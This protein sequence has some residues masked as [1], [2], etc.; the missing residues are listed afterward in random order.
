[1][2]IADFLRKEGIDP[3]ELPRDELEE[4]RKNYLTELRSRLH[5]VLSHS[6]M[7]RQIAAGVKT[8]KN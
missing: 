1:M 5:V 2:T 4:L 8:E 6:G 7:V 3:Y